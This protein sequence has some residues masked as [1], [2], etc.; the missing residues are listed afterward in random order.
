M[1]NSSIPT[2]ISALFFSVLLLSFPFSN[3]QALERVRWKLQIGFAGVEQPAKRL[4]EQ[5]KSISEGKIKL[6]LY[7]VNTLVPGME[8]HSAVGSGQ[9]DAGFTNPG[10]FANKIPAVIFFGGVPFGPRLVEHNAWMQH[11]GGQRLKDRIYDEQGLVSLQCGLVP[12]ESGGWFNKPYVRIE[13]LKGTKM[14]IWGFGGKVLKKFGVVPKELGAMDIVPALEKGVIDAAEFSTPHWDYFVGIHK[15]FKYN[16]YPGWIQPIV[17]PELIVNKLKWDELSDASRLIIRTSCDS[18]LLWMMVMI[19]SEQPQAMRKIKQKGVEFVTWRDSELNKLRKA[20]H[21]VAEEESAK[22][23]L[24][25]EVY[26]SYKSF[27]EQ[28]AIWGDRAYLN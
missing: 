23:P 24:F 8:L 5:I 28:Y 13:E 26:K 7:K 20:W 22:D 6:R 21:E 9:L 1:K 18:L 2:W 15:V 10:Y 4:I 25:A 19:D 17:I 14:R 16:Y 27:R 11:G 12:P 3:L